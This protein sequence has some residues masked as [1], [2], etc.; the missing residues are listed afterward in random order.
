M[1]YLLLHIFLRP[2]VFFNF[3]VKV[4]NE[5]F[6]LNVSLTK[7]I[8]TGMVV[9]KTKQDIAIGNYGNLTINVTK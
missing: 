7:S 1:L 9:G 3:S 6:S 2:S 5:M 4:V 8:A